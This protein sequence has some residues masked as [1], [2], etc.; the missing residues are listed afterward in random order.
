MGKPGE[1]TD[2][3]QAA[4]SAMPSQYRDNS[5]VKENYEQVSVDFDGLQSFQTSMGQQVDAN[6]QPHV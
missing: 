3:D 1:F 6:L 4:Q 5:G 2:Q